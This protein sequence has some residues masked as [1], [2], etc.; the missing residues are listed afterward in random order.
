M[1]ENL[2]V[3]IVLKI[4]KYLPIFDARQLKFTS[5]NLWVCIED[6]ENSD[7]YTNQLLMDS[8]IKMASIV[9]EKE[10][11]NMRNILKFTIDIIACY[12]EYNAACCIC[13]KCPGCDKC[14]SVFLTHIKFHWKP[15]NKLLYLYSFGFQIRCEIY[16]YCLEWCAKNEFKITKRF[17]L[18]SPVRDELLVYNDKALK[19][20]TQLKKYL[21]HYYFKRCT[22]IREYYNICYDLHYVDEFRPIADENTILTMAL[23]QQCYTEHDIYGILVDYYRRNNGMIDSDIISND[24]FILFG[25]GSLTRNF[26]SII[27]YLIVLYRSGVP[28]IDEKIAK[29]YNDNLSLTASLTR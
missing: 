29:L 3:E 9:Q 20:T 23:L 12:D 2:P 22:S 28:D 4:V 26:V 8:V 25:A 10:A 13:K 15:I 16:K 27:E 17:Q 5:K 21:F 11:V 14:E 24:I 19:F 7:E 6:Y 18:N 1:L